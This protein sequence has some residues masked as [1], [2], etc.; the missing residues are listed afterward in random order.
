LCSPVLV[1]KAYS[2]AY[3]GA[4]VGITFAMHAG[5]LP[6]SGQNSVCR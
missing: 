6:P 3:C 2:C 5:A 4:V 1:D